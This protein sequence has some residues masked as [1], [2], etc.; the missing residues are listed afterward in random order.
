MLL[1]VGRRQIDLGER[2]YI[3]V[4]YSVISEYD[5]E[6]MCD[7]FGVS[8]RIE[9]SGEERKLAGIT[10]LADEAF[11]LASVLINGKVTPVTLKDVV[12]DWIARI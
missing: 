6:F 10:S 5:N 4:V 11:Q 3:T 7:M 9:E 2:G 8:V 1:E 12:S